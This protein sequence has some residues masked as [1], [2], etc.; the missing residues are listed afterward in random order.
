MFQRH[1]FFVSLAASPLTTVAITQH[2]GRVVYDLDGPDNITCV[3][4]AAPTGGGAAARWG[5]GWAVANALPKSLEDHVHAHRIAVVYER[6]VHECLSRGRLLLPCRDYPDSIAYDP[7]LFADVRFTTTQ[8]PLQLK[9]NIVA[10][11]QFYGATYH[12]DMLDTTNLLVFSHTRLPPPTPSASRADVRH[13]RSPDGDR[14]AATP[15]HRDEPH[16]C[17]RSPGQRAAATPSLTKLAAARLHGIPCV[18]PQWVQQ[19]LSAGA[20]QPTHATVADA[21][22]GGTRSPPPPAVCAPTAVNS[23][24]PLSKALETDAVHWRVEEEVELCVSDAIVTSTAPHDARES[25]EVREALRLAAQLV[26]TAPTRKRRR[27][28]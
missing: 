22:P 9:A 21:A 23:A 2:G 8:L 3:V 6:W 12:S 20:M 16:V 13:T 26:P 4:I 5:R 14:E 11:L 28:R 7:Q 19:S 27:T 10:L 25:E 1:V 18:T 24:A 17:A 15:H